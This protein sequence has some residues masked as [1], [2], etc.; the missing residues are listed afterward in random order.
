MADAVTQLK[1]ATTPFMMVTVRG[2]I[3][4][5]R[6]HDDKVLTHIVTP[7]KDEYSKPQTVEVRSRRKLGEREDIVTIECELGGYE[8]KQFEVRDRETGEVSRVQPVNLTLDA[9]E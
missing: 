5:S 4:R 7:A 8:R 2:K 1:T 6:R 3:V 9:V